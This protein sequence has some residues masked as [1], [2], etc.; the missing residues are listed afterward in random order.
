MGAARAEAFRMLDSARIRDARG[1]SASPC[2]PIADE[3]TTALD[4][5]IRAQTPN[6]AASRGS[7]ASGRPS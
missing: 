4:V 1:L 5:T 2:L 7:P 3:Q 6:A